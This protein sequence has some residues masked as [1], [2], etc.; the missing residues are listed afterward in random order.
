MPGPVAEG[1]RDLAVDR[2]APSSIAHRVERL[3]YRG[4]LAEGR[5]VGVFVE[6]LVDL[7]G[8]GR[9]AEEAVGGLPLASDGRRPRRGGIGPRAGRGFCSR[10][11][12]IEASSVL[13]PR[14]RT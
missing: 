6:A 11:R 7:D 9:V 4:L 8:E 5:P 1:S 13:P 12:F 3:E 14:A 10:R 2:E